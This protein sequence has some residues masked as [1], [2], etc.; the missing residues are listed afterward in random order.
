VG[1]VSDG[2]PLLDP[3]LVSDCVHC[4][5]CLPTCPTYLLWNEEM[6]SPRGRIYLMGSLLAEE[7]DVNATTVRHWD[8]CL[9]CMACVTACPSDVRYDR[10]IEGTR[11]EVEERY[12]RPP[13]DR[14]L[15]ELVFAVMPHPWRMRAALAFA[16][17]GRRLPAPTTLRPLLELAPP[18]A[19]ARRPPELTP[20]RGQRAGR[21]G[22]LLGCVARV[23]FGGVNCATARL[24][25]ADGIEVAAPAGQACCGALHVHA[26][27][28]EE[29]RTRARATIDAFDAAGVDHVVTNAAGC[30]S[31]MKE[32]GGLLAGDARYAER[33]AAFAER[34][35]DVSELVTALEPRAERHP[36]QMRVAFQDSCHLLHAQG[37]QSQPRQMLG[38]I[39]DLELVEVSEQEICCGSAGIYNIVQPEPAAELGARKARNVLAAGAEAYASG[40]PGCLVQVTRHLREAG[41]P[42]P[43]FHPV[44]L[45]DA[46]LRGLD[47]E[48]MLARARR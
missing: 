20:A 18:W 15:R 21:A 12:R 16:P 39:P 43:A 13:A 44:E 25:A 40:N 37:V 46:S 7:V 38:Q 32:Y 4:G 9:G 19:S 45:L 35:R 28:L 42:L 34:V 8:Q 10:L 26:G 24:L 3:S 6:D 1:G 31:V 22:L 33:A 23:V 14:A 30:G 11:A 48:R 47:P 41:Q 29:G 5:F 17:L 27:R 36:L 2:G